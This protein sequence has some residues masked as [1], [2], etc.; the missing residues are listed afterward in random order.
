LA[1]TPTC[2]ACRVLANLVEAAND[3]FVS[4]IPVA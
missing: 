1:A 4:V 2:T 3:P